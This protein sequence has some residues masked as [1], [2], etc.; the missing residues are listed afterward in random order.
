MLK[1][2]MVL[3]FYDCELPIGPSSIDGYLFDEWDGFEVRLR[4]GGVIGRIG[5]L[6]RVICVLGW[7]LRS[8]AIKRSIIFIRVFMCVSTT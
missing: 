5:D 7:R 1:L 2:G 6:I 4:G 3:F 8:M